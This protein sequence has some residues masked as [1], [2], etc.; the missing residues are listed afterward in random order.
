MHLLLLAALFVS[1]PQPDATQP[2]RQPRLVAVKGF[3]AVV[4]GSGNSIWMAASRD[5]GRSFSAAGEVAR[6]PVLALG[7][8]RGPRIV[9]SG[10]TIVVSAVYGATLATG[11]HAHGL[12]ADGDLV[13]WRS[14]DEG[15]SWS[16]PVVVNDVSG[17][18]REGLHAMT[19]GRGGELA[20]VWLD[21]RSS[22]TELYGS[23]SRDQ[24]ATWSPN[25]RI[26]ASPGGT[27]CQCCDPSLAATGDGSFS[28]MFRNVVD[29]K[30]D[31]YLADWELK[32]SEPQ[33]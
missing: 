26:Y 29:G 16:K 22:G 1:I 3:S 13:A 17:S 8:H 10:K 31:M 32:C 9:I 5:E 15:R 2:N 33:K 23:Y 25:V 30:R 7:R 28:V 6:V 14:T 24:G 19:V 21:L 11:P 12:P 27:I 4:F 20:A 18:A